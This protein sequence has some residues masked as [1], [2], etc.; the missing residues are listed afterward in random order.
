MNLDLIIEAIKYDK[1]TVASATV[2]MNF[3]SATIYVN[4]FCEF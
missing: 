4:E 2:L 3:A 1:S